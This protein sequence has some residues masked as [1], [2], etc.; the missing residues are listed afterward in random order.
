MSKH[1]NKK[2][3]K[4]ISKRLSKIDW[5]A[6]IELNHPPHIPLFHVDENMN[7]IR[8]LNGKEE[9]VI[10]ENGQFVVKT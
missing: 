8:K 2:H 9:I 4:E 1:A 3:I 10:Y 7:L 5:N 6:G